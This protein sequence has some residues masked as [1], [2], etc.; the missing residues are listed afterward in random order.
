MMAFLKYLPRVK[1][2][3]GFILFLAIVFFTDRENMFLLAAASATLHE[4]AHIIMIYICG[5]YIE[6]INLA[7]YGAY[8]ELGKYPIIS[9]KKELLIA[10]AGPVL[11][12]TAACA[13]S[14]AGEF[15]NNDTL[16]VIA[17]INLMLAA[18]N[19]IPAYPLDGGRILKCALMMFLDENQADFICSFFAA[20]SAGAVVIICALFNFRMGFHPSMTIFCAFV[21]F[22]FVKNIVCR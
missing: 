9:Y 12:A 6:N 7:V 10:A 20:V 5:G 22:A 18:L 3:V 13:F 14:F 15:F 4:A 16:F 17:G 21:A 1:V 11:S 19:L 2:N 8:I